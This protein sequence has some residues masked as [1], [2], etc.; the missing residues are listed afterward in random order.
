M[1]RHHAVAA[2]FAAGGLGHLYYGGVL[3]AFSSLQAILAFVTGLALLQAAVGLGARHAWTF[4]VGAGIAALVS[5]SDFQEILFGSYGVDALAGV[6]EGVG[7][8]LVGVAALAWG[9]VRW[10]RDRVD[11]RLDEDAAVLALRV[12]ALLAALSSLTYVVSNAVSFGLVWSPWLPGNLLVVGGF[13]LVAGL[14]RAPLLAEEPGPGEPD[15]DP[16]RAGRPS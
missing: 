10:D 15:P 6:L 9:L 3:L 13:G 2:G 11:D 16:D 1:L 7:L 8:G 5:L 12:G 4:G 14:A